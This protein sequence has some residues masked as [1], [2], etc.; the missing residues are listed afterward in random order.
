MRRRLVIGGIVLA[1]LLLA[2]LGVVISL[3]RSIASIAPSLN[4]E[5]ST[6]R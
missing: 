3:V 6:A 4:L 1:A 5:R 2:V